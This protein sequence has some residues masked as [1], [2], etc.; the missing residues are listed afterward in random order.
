[1]LCWSLPR[2][3]NRLALALTFDGFTDFYRFVG[4]R[5]HSAAG[6]V[7]I[8]LGAA[9]PGAGALVAWRDRPFF[10][11]ITCGIPRNK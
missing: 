6:V 7:P 9:S 1:M 8:G 10:H 2:L 5:R 4:R 3:R 11:G